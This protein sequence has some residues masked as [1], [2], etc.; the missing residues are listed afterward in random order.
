MK[1]R[2]RERDI[3]PDISCKATTSG[4]CACTF[5]GASQTVSNAG[6]Y[7]TTGAGL[8]TQTPTGGAPDDSDYCAK[9]STLTLEAVKKA[10]DLCYRARL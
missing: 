4:G 7:T 3:D 8:L 6:T 1:E 2:D 5:S 10:R 9:G